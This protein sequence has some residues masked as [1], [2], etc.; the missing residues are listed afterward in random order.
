MAGREQIDVE[1]RPEERGQ[2][3]AKEGVRE[4]RSVTAGRVRRN[5]ASPEVPRE[6]S[7]AVPEGNANRSRADKTVWLTAMKPKDHFVQLWSTYRPL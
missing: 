3:A 4:R 2:K 5:S 6:W 1:V 7:C